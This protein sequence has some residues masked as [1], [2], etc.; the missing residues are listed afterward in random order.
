MPKNLAFVSCS[1]V[2]PSVNSFGNSEDMKRCLHNAF[3][4]NRE[5]IC[6]KPSRDTFSSLLNC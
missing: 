3:N 6:F 2:M 4:I 5:L 1:R